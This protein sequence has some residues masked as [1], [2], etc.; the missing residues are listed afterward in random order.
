MFEDFGESNCISSCGVFID[1]LY[2]L[3]GCIFLWFLVKKLV[4]VGLKNV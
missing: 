2:W 1:V 3:L 4:V